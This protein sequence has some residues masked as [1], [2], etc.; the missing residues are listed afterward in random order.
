LWNDFPASSDVIGQH[1][2]FSLRL[3]QKNLSRNTNSSVLAQTQNQAERE[4]ANPVFT[5][6]EINHCRD[7]F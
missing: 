7:G 6:R 5:A 3:Q 2:L 4:L 1:R